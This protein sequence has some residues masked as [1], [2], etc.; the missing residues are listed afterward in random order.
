MVYM[1]LV[2]WRGTRGSCWLLRKRPVRII[3]HARVW[4]CS[5][6]VI[7][8]L[9]SWFMTFSEGSFTRELVPIVN[10]GLHVNAL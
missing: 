4:S 6:A 10:A 5:I 8:K 7:G 9:G 1:R 3:S 2:L